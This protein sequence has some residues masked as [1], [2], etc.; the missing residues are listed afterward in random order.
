LRTEVIMSDPNGTKRLYHLEY[1]NYRMSQRDAD[2]FLQILHWYRSHHHRE[3]QNQQPYPSSCNSCYEQGSGSSNVVE[4]A[5]HRHHQQQQPYQYPSQYEGIISKASPSATPR[6]VF[7]TRGFDPPH[8]EESS[9][10]YT[11]PGGQTMY[12]SSG[13]YQM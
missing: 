6:D 9:S 13:F 10:F 7:Y 3:D 1:R 8:V 5:I 4:E 2:Q 11:S 12:P